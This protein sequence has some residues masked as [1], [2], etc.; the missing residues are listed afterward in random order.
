MAELE[1]LKTV[2]DLMCL[3]A[4][5]AP[6]TCGIDLVM[7][8]VVSGPEVARLAARMDEIG[9]RNSLP[10][11]HRDAGNLRATPVAVLIGVKA[12]RIGIR[13]CGQCGLDSCDENEEAGGT[14]AFNHMDLGIA[15]CSAASV[16]SL[17]HADCRMMYTLGAAARELGLFEEEAVSA[18]GIPLSA[19]GKNPYFDRP[20]ATQS[21]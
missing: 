18:I 11:L 13:G 14:C 10:F 19:T 6:N 16:A 4:R 2:A 1:A 12:K 3:A 8:K 5:T 21:A 15:A 17:H 20:P 7:T 9:D